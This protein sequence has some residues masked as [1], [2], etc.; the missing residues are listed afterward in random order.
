MP[1]RKITYQRPS[2]E[3]CEIPVAKYEPKDETQLDFAC[4]T[5]C[6]IEG[7]GVKPGLTCQQ[8]LVEN[9]ITKIEIQ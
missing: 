5:I 8:A 7:F 1:I 9:G 4:R 2:G 6:L 3:T